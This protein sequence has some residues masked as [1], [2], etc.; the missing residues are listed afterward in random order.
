MKNTVM[1]ILFQNTY[2]NFV[3]KHPTFTIINIILGSLTP[4][5]FLFLIMI[6]RDSEKLLMI[7]NIFMLIAVHCIYLL[8]CS[9][10]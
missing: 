3:Q 8:F 9:V 6:I 10:N 1:K 4:I 2:A 7:S 5:F